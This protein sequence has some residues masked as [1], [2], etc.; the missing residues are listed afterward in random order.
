[1]TITPDRLQ[2]AY[3]QSVDFA[4]FV[5]GTAQ[6]TADFLANHEAVAFDADDRAVIEALPQRIEILAIV[7]DWC[8]D[9]VANLPIVARLAEASERVGLH[10]LVRGPETGDVADAYPHEGR[11]HIPT[12]VVFDAAGAELG[13]IVERTPEIHREVVALLQGFFA[14]HPELDRATFP[15]GLDDAAKAGLVRR[16]LGRRVELRDLERRT[17]LRALAALAAGGAAPERPAGADLLQP[18]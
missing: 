18:A 3:A 15:S 7:E 17:L 14:E 1:M 2:R 11:S 10:V 8:P 12:Y 5:A 4:T 13:V 16:S 9:V 6:H